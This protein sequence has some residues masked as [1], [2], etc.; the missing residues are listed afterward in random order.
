[1]CILMP[2]RTTLSVKSCVLLPHEPA[3]TCRDAAAAQID[4]EVFSLDR[5]VPVERV[6]QFRRHPSNPRDWPG[7]DRAS[8]ILVGTFRRRRHRPSLDATSRL[9]H[10]RS[11]ARVVPT[12]GILDV[13]QRRCKTADV[14]R[15]C[16]PIWISL[17][18]T[19]GKVDDVRNRWSPPPSS[20]Y[21]NVPLSRS[22]NDLVNQSNRRC[23]PRAAGVSRRREARLRTAGPD[24]DARRG[25]LGLVFHNSSSMP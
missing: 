14:R 24:I 19:H 10:I 23:S 16:C 21:G 1:M 8:R 9:W 18:N 11:R 2:P 4:V 3:A 17:P 7:V 22:E 25:A 15:R 13:L 6:L 12:P 20:G 5:P